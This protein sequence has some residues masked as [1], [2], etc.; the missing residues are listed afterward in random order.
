MMF[1]SSVL[2]FSCG[3]DDP[4]PPDP[5]PEP[6]P[7]LPTWKDAVGTFKTDGSLKLTID[8][9]AA[10]TTKTASLAAGTG[11]SAKITLTNIVPDGATIEIDNVTMTK[12]GEAK[13]T[14]SGETTVGGTVISIAGSL[15]DYA[16]TTKTLNLSVTR[17][18]SS[19][20]AANW[21]L[22]FGAGGADVSINAKTGDATT[23]ALL[24]VAGQMLGGLLAQKVTDVS[25]V[26]GEDGKFD[27]TWQV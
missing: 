7:V 8:D 26:L 27:V 5:N 25:L 10:A 17:K 13:Y 11:E 15:A 16:A 18:I 3:K 12:D 9:L 24:T 4:A 22:S 20:L 19:P 14:F 1:C 21:K 2:L 23:D 6:D